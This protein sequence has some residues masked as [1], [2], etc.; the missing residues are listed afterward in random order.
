MNPK[1]AFQYAVKKYG[2]SNFRRSILFIFDS[3]KEAEDKEA[4]IV[5]KEFIERSD[6]Y[7]MILDGEG[8]KPSGYSKNKI[9]QFDING[10]LLKEWN[11]CYDVSEFLNTWKE[12]LYQAIS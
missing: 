8:K 11:N 7:N 4:E 6:T 9:Y 3:E 1:Y 2:T 12:S 10:K 5:T